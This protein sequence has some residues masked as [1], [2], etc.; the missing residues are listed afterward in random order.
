VEA[1]AVA[2]KLDAALDRLPQ[3]WSTLVGER[4]LKLSGGEKQRV[5]IARAFLRRPRLLICD[6]ATSALDTATERGIMTS[7][8]ELARGRT[9]VF[10]AHR[11]ST[12]QHCDR[13][14]VVREG[15]VEEAG[16]HG[17]L[18]ARRGV[19]YDMWQMQA[20]QEVSGYCLMVVVVDFVQAVLCVLK[21]QKSMRGCIGYWS[22]AIGC[23]LQ[24][25][26]SHLKS[27][28]EDGSMAEVEDA[29]HRHRPVLA[30]K[31]FDEG[32]P[33]VVDPQNSMDVM[34]MEFGK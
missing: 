3:G 34:W 27:M 12:V 6:E 2:A 4:G 17:E 23:G 19:Y 29:D 14:Y 1:A 20:A 11:L 25:L 16:T 15:K 18:M 33:T 21:Q 31:S 5:A 10:V 8:E 13:I 24:E 22:S 7:L 28:G 26:E 9:S 30:S 32:G